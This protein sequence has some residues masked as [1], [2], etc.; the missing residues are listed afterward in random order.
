MQDAA[1]RSMELLRS[2]SSATDAGLLRREV[3]QWLRDAGRL[4]ALVEETLDAA[5][6]EV[7]E[8]EESAD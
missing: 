2:S 3:E 1:A 5:A 4:E 8:R 6:A 7:R